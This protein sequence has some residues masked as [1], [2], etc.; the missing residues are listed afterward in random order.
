MHEK[1]FN[2][3]DL[4]VVLKSGAR[5][6]VRVG[7]TDDRGLARPISGRVTGRGAA[8]SALRGQFPSLIGEYFPYSIREGG[9]PAIHC[10]LGRTLLKS[11]SDLRRTG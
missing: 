9:L 8:S 1:D 7:K 11:R 6:S 5:N 10:V 3:S 2:M 4:E